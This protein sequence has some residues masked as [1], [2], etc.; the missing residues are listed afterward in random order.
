MSGS[1]GAV[2][3]RLREAAGLSQSELAGQVP[4]DKSRLSRWEN[5]K[6][7]PGA[8]TVDRLDEL[9]GAHGDLRRAHAAATTPPVPLPECNSQQPVTADDIATWLNTVQHL[10]ALDGQ[11]GGADLVDYATRVFRTAVDRVATN[12]PASLTRDATATVA[13]LGEVAAWFA[14][15]SWRLRDARALNLE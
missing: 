5:N 14:F 2:L 15:D 7:T 9:V 4:V 6:S 1:F 13:E 8:A 12:C 11:H 10:V 3:R